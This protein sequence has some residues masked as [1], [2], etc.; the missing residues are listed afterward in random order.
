[1]ADV[2]AFPSQTD[3]QALVLHEAA[4]AGLPIVSVDHELN[5]VIEAGVN[6]E[7]TRPT[8]A[9]LAAGILRVLNRQADAA[10]RE[11]ARRRSIELAGQWSIASQAQAML[12]IYT[13]LADAAR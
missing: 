7:F 1:M 3:T 2:F 6:G 11:N 5:L 8:A 4:L 9:S 10:W 12:D 13:E